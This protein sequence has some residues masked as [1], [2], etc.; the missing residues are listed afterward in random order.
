MRGGGGGGEAHL[1]VFGSKNHETILNL[2]KSS[3]KIPALP[4]TV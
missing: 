3:S 1:Q 2:S 4:T